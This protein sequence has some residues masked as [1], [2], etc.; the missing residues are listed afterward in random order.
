MSFSE[1]RLYLANTVAEWRS[2]GLADLQFWHRGDG[3]LIV[4][5]LSLLA[6]FLLIARS[7]LVRQPGRHRLV[8]PAILTTLRPSYLGFLRHLPLV[9][10]VAGIPFLTIAVADPFSSLVTS[11]VSYPGRRI[12]VM[13]DAS[14]SMRT[15]FKA[16]HLNTRAETDATFFTTVA[17]AE[18]FVRMRASERYR[19]LMALIEFGNEAYVVTPFTND[20]DNILLS[21]SL[22]GDPV[23]YS[24][25]PDQGTIIA[26]AINQS[27]GLFRA[28]NFM[29]AAGNLMVLFSDGEDTRVQIGE[30]TLDEILQDSIDNKIPVYMVRTNYE[31]ERGKVIPDEIWIPAIE[32]T[33]GRFYAADNEDALLAA[34]NDIDKVAAGTIATRQYTSQR[35]RYAFF[36]MSAAACWLAAAALKLALPQFQKLP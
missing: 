5:G 30:K 3:R 21:I 6:V 35:P 25:F 36:A 31:R 18:R 11:E 9:L 32:K 7:F 17:A 12:A 23:E 10:F 28:F 8:V 2:V 24:L 4:L 20:Y 27:I 22:I 1:A 33:G 26:Q 34:I 13:I 19:D 29:D 14:T 16:S 15:P